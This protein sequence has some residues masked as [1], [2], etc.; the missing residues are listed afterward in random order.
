MLSPTTLMVGLCSKDYPA[1]VAT[2]A[3]MLWPGG[4]SRAK[5]LAPPLYLLVLAINLVLFLAPNGYLLRRGY[6][7]VVAFRRLDAAAA[8]VVRNRLAGRI[9]LA[10]V[11]T[12]G[13]FALPLVNLLAPNIA[14]AFMVYV[15]EASPRVEP[16]PAA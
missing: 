13:L 3:V 7:E 6:F 2:R 11:V 12:G 15:F 9:F 1:L 14:T 8:R 10:G 5:H 16:L 4:V